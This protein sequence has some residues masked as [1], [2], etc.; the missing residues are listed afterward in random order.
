MSRSTMS[1]E[2]RKPSVPNYR[3]I[4]ERDM[5]EKQRQAKN[6]DTHHGAR[7]LSLL[8][9]RDTVY[10]CDRD[11]TGTVVQETTP[12]SYEVRM[13]EGTFRQNRHH[14]VRTPSEENN[15]E[16]ICDDPNQLE[17]SL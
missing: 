6:Y 4:V 10:V 12:G 14:V 8:A 13:P 2:L 16:N 7:A 9:P 17:L 5:K 3:D 1:R 11:S 15:S